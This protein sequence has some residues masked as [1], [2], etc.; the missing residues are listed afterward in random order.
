MCYPVPLCCSISAFVN[1]VGIHFYRWPAL[2]SPYS[3]V[4]EIGNGSQTVSHGKK[5]QFDR[6]AFICFK[7]GIRPLFDRCYS[8]TRIP[9]PA[10]SFQRQSSPKIQINHRPPMRATLLCQSINNLGRTISI[11]PHAIVS[12][13]FDVPA[14]R[15]RF[16]F[17]F[18]LSAAQ[19]IFGSL[20]IYTPRA[21]LRFFGE[22]P[23]TWS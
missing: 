20:F 7:P 22:R 15:C 23:A 5:F 2:H 10:A 1:D 21:F 11:S 17:P 8:R 16:I 18:H 9:V 3:F 13:L 12:S 6:A 14:C 19:S 4:V